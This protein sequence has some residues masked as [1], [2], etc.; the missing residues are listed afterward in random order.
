MLSLIDRLKSLLLPLMISSDT[1]L[2]ISF[3]SRA[4]PAKS[5]SYSIHHH[6]DPEH[7]F[8]VMGTPV[9]ASVLFSPRTAFFCGD[10]QCSRRTMEETWKPAI[11]SS[12]VT[13][14]VLT[15]SDIIRHWADPTGWAW[16]RKVQWFNHSHDVTIITCPIS[17]VCPLYYSVLWLSKFH[18]KQVHNQSCL[19]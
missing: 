12:A 8:L 14:L 9:Q 3:S 11:A 5:Q 15:T 17:A 10:L 4:L 7:F 13:T 19:N 6:L 18:C 16:G 2:Y 1:C